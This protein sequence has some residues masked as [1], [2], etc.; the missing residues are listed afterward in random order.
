MLLLIAVRISV[1]QVAFAC[2]FSIT[3][4]IEETIR[5]LKNN[6]WGCK[7]DMS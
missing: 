3:N 5:L 2:F 7:F 4:W 6:R 1:V